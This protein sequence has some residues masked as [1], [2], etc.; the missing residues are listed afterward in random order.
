MLCSWMFSL[1]FTKNWTLWWESRNIHKKL[2]CISSLIRLF[3]WSVDYWLSL[4][5]LCVWTAGW[6]VAR[7]TLSVGESNGSAAGKQPVSCLSHFAS[8]PQR[9]SLLTKKVRCLP[10]LIFNRNA[11]CSSP[12]EN[13]TTTLAKV[14]KMAGVFSVFITNM[15]YWFL[16]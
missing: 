1:W 6:W 5:L 8:H 3:V 7:Y 15:K 14:L 10:V 12:W 11:F 2:L 13:L 16:L 9:Q 4:N